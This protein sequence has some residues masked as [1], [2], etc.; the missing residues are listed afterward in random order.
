M[1]I[2]T[3]VRLVR[4]PDGGHDH[5]AGVCTAEGVYFSRYDVASAIDAGEEWWTE[6]DGVRARIR[7]APACPFPGC[8]TPYLMTDQGRTPAAELEQ[9]PGC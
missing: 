4:A 7:K 6:R 3:R 9:L 8:A 2:V 1:P 5:L